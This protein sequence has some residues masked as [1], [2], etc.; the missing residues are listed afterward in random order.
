MIAWL[1]KR[2]QLDLLE[3][4]LR[5]TAA[6]QRP[7]VR[8]RQTALKKRLM[9]RI[10]RTMAREEVGFE[11]LAEQLEKLKLTVE[12]SAAFKMHAKQGVLD[13]LT[14]RNQRLWLQ[15]LVRELLAHRRVWAT[16]TACFLLVAFT[17]G[18]VIQMPMVEAAKVSVVDSFRGTA[19]VERAGAI[20][21]LENG[22][23]IQEGDVIV[24]EGDGWADLVFVDDSLLT[25]G[26]ETT[27]TLSTLWVDLENEAN[28]SVEVDVKQGRVWTKVVNL[29]AGGSLFSVSVDEAQFVVERKATFDVMASEEGTHL[30]VFS[31]LVDFSVRD[32]ETVRDGTLG[33]NLTMT[34]GD[35][36]LV[37]EKIEDVKRLAQDDVWV[38][39]NLDNNEK[40]LE[41][42]QAFY[43]E[44]A[45]QQAGMLPGDRL[46]FLERSAEKARLMM[47]FGEE[48]WLDFHRH[49]A[50]KRF[51]EAAVLMSQGHA[52]AAETV[53]QDYQETLVNLAGKSPEYTD[54][55]QAVLAESKKMMDGVGSTEES[56]HGVRA[57][58][59][60]TSALLVNDEK[61][62]SVIHLETAANRLELALDLI[63]IGAYDLA[64]QA[65][66]DYQVG[67]TDVIDG[68]SELELEARKEVVMEILDQKLRDL[69]MLKLISAQLYV[70]VNGEREASA[71]VQAEVESV[72]ADTL[73]QLNTLVLN[74]KDRAVLQLGV[75]LEDV[76]YDEEIQMQVLSSLKKSVDLDFEFMQTIND[77]ESFYADERLDVVIVEDEVVTSEQEEVLPLEEYLHNQVEN[78]GAPQDL[79]A[80]AL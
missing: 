54:H 36:E 69:Q 57:V 4:K 40:Y 20:L 31:H 46:Y 37:I 12:P 13:V 62:R 18:Y 67:L 23:L 52:E 2:Q 66:Q 63:E 73:I 9:M 15:D 47:T 41:R 34:L 59:E 48:A 30:R 26:P 68:L 50:E 51:S 38:Q 72:Y 39:T 7:M 58:V 19:H 60:E 28:T 56:F 71:E 5:E 75:F 8:T 27:L 80:G 55:A 78:T 16:V 49:L 35:G 77:L 14:L 1:K 53:L 33:P 17:L 21:P 25:V 61:E 45:T 65:I 10:D 32:G 43:E 64:L 11:Q 79:E 6:R 22:F 44:R 3:K 74:L 70:L 24:T 76:K 42:L 29:A